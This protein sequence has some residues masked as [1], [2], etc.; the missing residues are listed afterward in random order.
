MA[1]SYEPEDVL[2]YYLR[3]QITEL[4][5]KELGK[6]TYSRTQTFS[7]DNSTTEF[8]L[9]SLPLCAVTSVSISSVA[10]TEFVNYTVDYENN[11]V[12]FSSAPAS[13]SSNI[14]ISYVYGINW[15]FAGEARTD[16][17]F[18]SY[19][20]IS[21]QALSEQQKKRMGLGEYDTLDFVPFQ[22]DILCVAKQG[23]LIN[24][25]WREGAFVARYLSREVISKLKLVEQKIGAQLFHPAILNNISVPFEQQFNR[26]R[27]V[28]DVRL[29][30]FNAGEQ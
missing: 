11:K 14:S 23:L 17:S 27:R 25:L 20:R 13:G 19:P 1:V 6:R 4:D 9:T 2:T 12:V 18:E 28:V 16:L 7:G 24:G 30:T 15:I 29:E 5:R 8:S 3:S 22:I 10:Q 26:Y 21:V